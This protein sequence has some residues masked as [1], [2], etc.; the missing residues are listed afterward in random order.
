MNG[1]PF[2]YRLAVESDACGTESTQV[3]GL[4]VSTTPRNAWVDQQRTTQRL[5]SPL[6]A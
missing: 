6:S 4:H 3:L 5:H 1:C 2:V